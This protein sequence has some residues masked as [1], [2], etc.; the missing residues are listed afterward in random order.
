MPAPIPAL[1]FETAKFALGVLR[2]MGL[3]HPVIGQSAVVIVWVL[4]LLSQEYVSSMKNRHTNFFYSSGCQLV[5]IVWVRRGR[6]R[7]V[8]QKGI[9]VGSRVLG[10]TDPGVS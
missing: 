6:R 10:E 3:E 5:S 8:T 7:R 1:A 2:V 4:T 9:M